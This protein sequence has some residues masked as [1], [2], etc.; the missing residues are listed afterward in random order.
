[1][2]LFTTDASV[3]N[4]GVGFLTI[5]AYVLPAYVLLYICVS[6]M[7]GIKMPLFGLFIGLSRQIVGPLFVFNLF[8]TVMGLGLAGIWWGIFGITW[9]AALIVVIYVSRTLAKLEKDLIKT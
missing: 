8:V 6:A 4:I 1:M 9:T 5:E 7:Q 2:G 3:I